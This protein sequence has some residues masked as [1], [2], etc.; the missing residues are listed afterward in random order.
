MS[1]KTAREIVSG[2]QN[3]EYSAKDVIEEV[4]SRIEKYDKEINAIIELNPRA[5]EEAYKIDRIKDK[6]K[7]P[8][9]GL[10]IVVKCNI[11][12]KGLHVSAASRMLADYTAPYDATVVERLK[13]AGAIIVGL[14]NSDEFAMGSTTETSFYGPTR[15][16]IDPSRVPGGSSGGSAAAVAAGYVPVSLGSDT[17]GSIRCPASYCGIVG[18]K[19][20][21]GRVSRY[22]LIPYAN[23]I[24]QI[25]PMARN[26]EDLW[27]IF[28]VI[29][30]HDPKDATTVKYPVP[31]KIKRIENPHVAVIKESVEEPTNKKI[32]DITLRAAEKI[33]PNFD[34]VHVH[35]L[36]KS[37]AAYYIIAMA[38]AS[39]NLA[40]F[41]G[42]RYGFRVKTA[43]KLDDVISLNRAKGFGKE[44][45]KRILL[46]TFVLSAGYMG[47]YYLRAIKV[48]Q[49][50][51][52]E[53]Q[54]LLSNYDVLIT[55][56]MPTLPFKIG[57]VQDPLVL[58][59]TDLL[60]T[61]VNLS[62]LPAI[63]V[64]V[65]K[66]NG[67][68]VGVQII[69]PAFKEDVISGIASKIIKRQ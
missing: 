44:V 8:L 55:P 49:Q 64:P 53:M 51:I 40:R 36:K 18:L 22:G 23:S 42:I 14:A 47:Q 39:S 25:G 5:L 20:T 37:V 6:S 29:A 59:K 65:G 69:G 35:S 56:T 66:I 9:A 54:K 32:A 50:I 7:L 4:F 13:A 31:R 11:H 46:G 52:A 48:R 61:F 1:E 45:K 17:G 21:Y 26:V 41:D 63:S 27:L 58:Y 67:L 3:G 60:T 34:I 28:S 12:V 57:E 62:G 24:E 16:P 33:D 19:P 68:P 43:G 10:P 30:G 15:N 38:E 2:I